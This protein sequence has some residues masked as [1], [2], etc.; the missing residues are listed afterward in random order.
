MT[1]REARVWNARTNQWELV[2]TQPGPKGDPGPAGTDGVKFSPTPPENPPAGL[3]WV[4][5][6]SDVPTYDPFPSQA[7]QAGKV[8]GTDGSRVSWV[9]GGG[10]SSL[11]DSKGLSNATLMSTDGALRW[12]ERMVTWGTTISWTLPGPNPAPI[13]SYYEIDRNTG[14]FPPS[15]KDFRNRYQMSVTFPYDLFD[16]ARMEPVAVVCNFE[17]N[18]HVTSWTALYNVAKNVS[19]WST[20]APVYVYSVAPAIVPGQSAPWP[21]TFGMYKIIVTG[22][23]KAPGFP[24]EEA[25]MPLRLGAYAAACTNPA[26]KNEGVRFV[27]DPDENG[28]VP[29][30]YCGPCGADLTTILTKVEAL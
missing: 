29:G 27:V 23:Q 1:T 10:G 21:L 16:T 25:S 5:S 11:P 24:K 2:G 26:C 6:D 15:I 30:L 14:Q 17:D 4:K 22:Y 8:L 28:E 7:G 13:V 19:R 18:D 3:L 9:A 12:E 20:L